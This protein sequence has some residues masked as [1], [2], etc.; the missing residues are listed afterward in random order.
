MRSRLDR[1]LPSEAGFPADRR[2]ARF[3]LPERASSDAPRVRSFPFEDGSWRTLS[4]AVRD[5]GG[6]SV[7]AALVCEDHDPEARV[8]GQSSG[9]DSR[10]RE[11]FQQRVTKVSHWLN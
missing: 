4:S 9:L 1:Q 11:D 8:A 3:V 7:V 10:E 6:R 2:F 5:F